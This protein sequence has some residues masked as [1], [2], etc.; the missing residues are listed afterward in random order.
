[1]STFL[2][3]LFYGFQF[4]FVYYL[5][6]F[7]IILNIFYLLSFQSFSICKS[8][9]FYILSNCTF[10]LQYIFIC[11]YL[12]TKTLRITLFNFTSKSH[13]RRNFFSSQVYIHFSCHLH[14]IIILKYDLNIL[15]AVPTQVF[16]HSLC[17]ASVHFGV[18][19]WS[20]THMLCRF[21]MLLIVIFSSMSVFVCV[22]D[23]ERRILVRKW[24]RSVWLI[25]PAVNACL[26]LEPLERDWRRAATSTS[27]TTAAGRHIQ[28]CL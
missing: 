9:H 18:W 12:Y 16:I 24:V 22:C 1:M 19:S 26:R 10:L 15:F 5:V 6:S 2:N 14:Q 23:C 25:W 4:L 21:R 27:K 11:I 7:K 28:T 20:Q 17:L 3:V 13:S 8:I